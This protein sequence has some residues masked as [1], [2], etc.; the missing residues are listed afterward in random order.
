MEAGEHFSVWKAL[1]LTSC[2]LISFAQIVWCASEYKRATLLTLNVDS[3]DTLNLLN[4]RPSEIKDFINLAVGLKVDTAFDNQLRGNLLLDCIARNTQYGIAVSILNP[5]DSEIQHV[6]A[7]LSENHYHIYEP[8]P[9]GTEKL[10]HYLMSGKPSDYCHIVDAINSRILTLYDKGWYFFLLTIVM[11]I[12]MS[13][14]FG[15]LRLKKIEGKRWPVNL[16][17]GCSIPVAIVVLIVHLPDFF[18]DLVV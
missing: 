12:W 11:L 15:V 6:L 4:S 18:C 5:D 8:K 2:L 1:V 17:I 14:A 9:T 3:Y 13:F 16:F 10:F 7:L